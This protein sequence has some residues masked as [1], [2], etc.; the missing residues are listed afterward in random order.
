MIRAIYSPYYGRSD[1]ND[2]VYNITS[3]GYRRGCDGADYYVYRGWRLYCSFWRLNRVW[4]DHVADHQDLQTKEEVSP[5][6]A[7]LLFCSRGR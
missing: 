3:I 5:Q 4:F 7:P 2:L 6:W 1:K